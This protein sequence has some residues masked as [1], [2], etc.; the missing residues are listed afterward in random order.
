MGGDLDVAGGVPTRARA[1]FGR[2]DGTR[3]R[4]VLGLLIEAL[5]RDVALAGSVGT[6]DG[7]A[8]TREFAIAGLFVRGTK[9]RSR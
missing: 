8:H 5:L 6:L 1:L 3:I 9:G 2:L 7:R 4:A